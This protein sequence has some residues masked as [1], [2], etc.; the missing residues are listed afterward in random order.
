MAKLTHREIHSKSRVS[1]I[2]EE[3]E[4]SKTKDRCSVTAVIFPLLLEIHPWQHKGMK[5]K[6]NL[7]QQQQGEHDIN[8]CLS[9]VVSQEFMYNG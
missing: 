4:E 8:D 2:S 5:H 1:S 7:G 3:V 9:S 6:P